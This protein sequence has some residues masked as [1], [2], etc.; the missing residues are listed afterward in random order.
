MPQ[1][2]R[3]G[4]IDLFAGPGGLAE[5]FSSF[6]DAGGN[7]RFRVRLSI[8][9]EARA[10]QTLTLRSFL[11]Q[12][13]GAT[14]KAYDLFLR[15]RLPLG[16]LYS[17]HEREFI[18][19]QGEARQLTLGA[20]SALEVRN[21]VDTAVDPDRPWVLVGGP[22]CQAYSLIGR[23]RN[24]GIESYK[25]TKDVRQ[26]LYI[27]Y[28]QILADHAPPAFVME[29]VKGLLSATLGHHR[30]FD[31]IRSDLI[32]PAKALKR[33]GRRGRRRPRYVLH[34]FV[35][36]GDLFPDLVP[37]SFVIRAEDYGVPQARHRVI[38]LGIREGSGGKAPEAIVP[39]KGDSVQETIANLPPLRSG[40]TERMDGDSEWLSLLRGVTSR[41]WFRQVTTPVQREIRRV[42]S[43][44][45]PP[46]S[47]RGTERFDRALGDGP[48]CNHVSKAHIDADLERYLFASC[49][50]SVHGQSP[51]IQDLPSRLRPA[52]ASAMK[53]LNGGHFADRF[54][55]QA[56]DRSATT[57]TS[58]IAK[59]G[60]YYIHYDPSQCRSLTVREAARLQTFP[61]DYF[62]CGPRTSQYQQ[63]GNAVPPHIA[64]QLAHVVSEVLR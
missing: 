24:R 38:I 13:E 33:E 2:N 8:E 57:I 55:V 1:A 16:A 49:W 48:V 43:G 41:A 10:H 51:S 14:P 36:S 29:N 35:Q 37:S 26:T 11:R 28:L 9:K 7:S 22:P 12:F 62:F 18:K 39:K 34:S 58:H 15:D 23:S 52:H 64:S 25:P 44:I 61:D 19:A 32:D 60:H 3:I 63:V 4:V 42:V 31:R 50:T 53:A 21:L 17:L 40:L 20:E 54:R 30:L 45:R 47:G 59:D 5:G 46:E 6:R 27:E 56:A